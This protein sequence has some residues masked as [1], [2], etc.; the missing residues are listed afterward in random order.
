MSMLEIHQFLERLGN[1]IRSQGRRTSA[2]LD[3][4]PVH[5]NALYYLS[6]CN[7]Y[8]D[9]LLAV[10]EYLGQ[11][12]G[13][14]SQTIKL[15]EQRRLLTKKPDPV[16]GRVTHLKLTASGRKIV[17]QSWPSPVLKAAESLFPVDQQDALRDQ[18]KQLLHTCQKVND[19]KTFAIC[20]SCRH[21][22]KQAGGYFCRLTQEPLSPEDVTLICREHEFPQS[23]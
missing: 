16:D 2:G 12:R 6:I 22:E 3:L 8:S 11:T 17:L 10:S 4:Q 1:L 23:A 9:T 13:T 18:L 14:T 20:H 5:L 7:R 21:N 15:L 19:Q